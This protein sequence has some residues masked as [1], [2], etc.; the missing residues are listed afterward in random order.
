M[1][2]AHGPCLCQLVSLIQ[3]YLLDSVPQSQ[4]G[5]YKMIQPNDSILYTGAVSL[6]YHLAWFTLDPPFLLRMIAQSLLPSLSQFVESHI[7][8]NCYYIIIFL[9]LLCYRNWCF[10]RSCTGL[11]CVCSHTVGKQY[12]LQYCT[13]I[14]YSTLPSYLITSKNRRLPQCLVL[15]YFMYDIT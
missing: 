14:C 13:F 8:G 12:I 10:L 3:Y 1:C 6:G 2:I 9:H 15:S 11:T 4:Q 7:H 5:K